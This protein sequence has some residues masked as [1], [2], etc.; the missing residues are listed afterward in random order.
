MKWVD[1]IVLTEAPKVDW[2]SWVDAHAM[3]TAE[4]STAL[5]TWVL[6]AAVSGDCGVG[7][8]AVGMVVG[9]GMVVLEL[10]GMVV[11]ELPGMVNEGNKEQITVEVWEK[12]NW[13][14]STGMKDA[15]AWK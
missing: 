13:N 5:M 1:D 4:S 10:P 7:E 15:L 8:L 9:A 2:T 3:R 12:I 11:L 6:E 14:L